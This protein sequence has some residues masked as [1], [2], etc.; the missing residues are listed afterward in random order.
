MCRHMNLPHVARLIRPNAGLGANSC[1]GG[2]EVNSSSTRTSSSLSR[3]NSP[4]S[5]IPV[6][7]RSSGAVGTP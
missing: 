4:G 1:P 2:R 6:P 3:A 7:A 5:V